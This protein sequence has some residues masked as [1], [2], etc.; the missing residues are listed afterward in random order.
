MH[1]KYSRSFVILCFWATD[2][3]WTILTMSLLAAS[4]HI[5]FSSYIAVWVRVLSDLIKNTVS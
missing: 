5:E 2:V 4:L 1:K 3:T